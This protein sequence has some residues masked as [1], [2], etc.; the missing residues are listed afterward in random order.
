MTFAPLYSGAIS[1]ERADRLVRL[2]KSR[3][4][5]LPWPVPSTPKNSD[6]FNADKYWQ[7]P[8]WINTN[9]LIIDGL[10]RYGYDKEADE[11]A[12][13]TIKLVTKSGFFEYY[14]PLNASGNGADNFSWSAALTIDL[15]RN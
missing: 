15:L 3:H 1:A 9:W 14:N 2:L 12:A 7:G 11:L 8:T 4:Y 6:Y 5:N 10:R 13:K